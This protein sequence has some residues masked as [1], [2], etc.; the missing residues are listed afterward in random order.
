MTAEIKEGDKFLGVSGNM[1]PSLVSRS[2]GT[3]DL[4]LGVTFVKTHDLL[5]DRRGSTIGSFVGEVEDFLSGRPITVV[6]NGL[7]EHT[8]ECRLTG[9]DVSNNGDT[10]IILL[11]HLKLHLG[12]LVL[13]LIRLRDG[14]DFKLSL[15]LKVGDLFL[16]EVVLLGLL[17]LLLEG[18]L[19]LVELLV[20]LCGGL[21]NLFL[22]PSVGLLLCG[23][24]FWLLLHLFDINL[25]LA[26]ETL[27]M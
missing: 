15:L 26:V 22:L 19:H 4:H 11:P 17:L 3:V 27:L 12:D 21:L 2:V 14:L 5:A 24:I 20:D 13:K 25:L 23:R 1:I 7:G 18:Q 16:G 6:H 10:C 9:V 8:N